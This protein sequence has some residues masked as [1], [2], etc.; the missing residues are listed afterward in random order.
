MQLYFVALLPGLAIQDEVTHF[1]REAQA[2]FGSGHALKSPPHVTL[3]PPFRTDRTSF[4]AL[5]DFAE[6]QLPFSVQLINFGRF[7]SRVI[8]VHVAEEQ[9]LLD[10]QQQLA[11]FC[12]RQLDVPLDLRPFHPHMTVAFRDLS[13]STFSEAWAY[14]SAQ[15]YERLFTAS[16]L[17]LLRHS[18]QKWEIV[19]EFPFGV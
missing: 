4:S 11:S 5:Q 12:H 9:A 15:P 14:F 1:K 3:I 6:Q 2:R 8:F 7:G 18:G 13:R 19:E 10:C 17:T 16:A